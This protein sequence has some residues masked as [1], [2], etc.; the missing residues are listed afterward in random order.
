MRCLF[1][2]FL[3]L[4][5][6]GVAASFPSPD[7]VEDRLRKE[8]YAFTTGQGMQ[9][10]YTWVRNEVTDAF[11]NKLPDNWLVTPRTLPDRLLLVTKER[12][13]AYNA[14]VEKVA[15]ELREDYSVV[16]RGAAAA[17]MGWG[18]KHEVPLSGRYDLMCDY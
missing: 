5:A 14:A 13:D 18:F 3:A 16:L 2:F 6:C 9:L 4:C 1:F 17:C 8:N 10:Y 15:E 7:Y 11:Y 12:V